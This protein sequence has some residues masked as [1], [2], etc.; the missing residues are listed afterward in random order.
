[1]KNIPSRA[2][3]IRTDWLRQITGLALAWRGKLPTKLLIRLY[4]VTDDQDYARNLTLQNAPGW[5]RN[6]NKPFD[7]IWRP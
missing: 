7:G 2:V 5:P 6:N 1:M 4:R 3:A